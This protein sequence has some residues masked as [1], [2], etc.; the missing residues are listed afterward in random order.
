[1][2]KR[3]MNWH[4]LLLMFAVTLVSCGPTTDEAIDYNDLIIDEQSAIDDKEVLLINSLAAED[5]SAESMKKALADFDAQVASGIE[6]LKGLSKFDD[7][8]VFADA[9]LKLFVL[10]DGVAKNEYKQVVEIYSKEDYTE[11]DLD[12]AD[13]L[14]D[15]IDEKLDGE[16]KTFQ[17]VQKNFAAK[18]NFKIEED[19][20][21]KEEGA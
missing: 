15:A 1:M 11:E 8:T 13:K 7:T 14:L 12:L 10:Y 21:D 16:M 19:K 4:W 3:I 20:K 5:A 18:Y 2:N 6:K 9:A 17:D